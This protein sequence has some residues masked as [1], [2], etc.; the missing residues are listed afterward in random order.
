MFRFL[1]KVKRTQMN[2]QQVWADYMG[3]K[4]L[5]TARLSNMTKIWLSR[6]HMA[7]LVDNLQY[8]LQVYYDLTASF[9]RSR[10][11]CFKELNEC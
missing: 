3:A 8:Y 6:M 5:S 9:A 7:F 10:F 11:F 2:L 4:H 1:L